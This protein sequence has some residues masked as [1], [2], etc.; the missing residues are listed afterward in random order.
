MLVL[1]MNELT[2]VPF[3]IGGEIVAVLQFRIRIGTGMQLGQKST[4][5][6]RIPIHGNPGFGEFCNRERQQLKNSSAPGQRLADFGFQFRLMTPGE[7]VLSHPSRLVGTHL[8]VTQQLRHPLYLVNDERS[9]MISQ[10]SLGILLRISP[11]FRFLQIHII[12]IFEVVPGQRCLAG[13]PRPGDRN[14]RKLSSQ[15]SQLRFDCSGYQVCLSL[16]LSNR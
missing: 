7:D 3:H 11:G 6:I 5:N 4:M 16:L 12:E 10:K 13:L 15:S 14:N 2:D 1:Q 9:R 8:N